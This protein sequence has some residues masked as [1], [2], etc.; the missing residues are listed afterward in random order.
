VGIVIRATVKGIE[1]RLRTAGTLFS[2]NAIDRGTLAMPSC[3]EF[4][5]D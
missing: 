5:P 2:P 1:L 3:V 4:Q